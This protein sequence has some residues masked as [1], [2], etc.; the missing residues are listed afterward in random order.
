[1]QLN[2]DIIKALDG[3]FKT[4]QRPIQLKLFAG[5]HEKRQELIDFLSKVASISDKV[6]LIYSDTDFNVREGLTFEVLAE[7]ESTSIR[8]SGIPGGHEFN[9]F[10]LAILNSGGHPIKLD[11]G[12]QRQVKAI[13]AE[14][15]FEVI[16]SLDCHNCPDVVQTLNQFSLLNPK[17]S[18]EM[19]DGGTHKAF[20]DELNVQGVPTIFLNR[21]PFSSGKISVSEIIEKI[22]KNVEIAPTEAPVDNT[23]YDVAIIGGGPAAASAAIYTARK[24]L[25][26]LMLA[27][28]VGGQVA[29]TMA[30]EN[31]ISVTHTTGPELT[32]SLR[33][34]VESYDVSIRE[35]IRVNHIAK[36]VDSDNWALGLN[37]NET[38]QSKSVV[39][40]TGAKWREL[41]VPGEKENIGK[42]VAY[43]PHCDGPFFKGKDV[44]VVGGGNSG[45]EAA[46]D[47]AGIVKS[48]TVV[49]FMDTLKAD[50]VLID[51]LQDT[52]NAKIIT[53]VATE[54]ILA[55]S[56]SVT[57]IS[58]KNRSDGTISELP[59]DGVFIQIGLAPNSG[60]VKELVDVNKF[61]EIEVNPRCETDKPGIFAC[62]DVTTVPYK[63]IVVSIGEGAKAGLSAFEYILKAPKV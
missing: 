27:E 26:V 39:I 13:D 52:Q 61:G 5:N 24:G 14:L 53:G 35:E 29:E 11:E 19:I 21:K 3:Y 6:E 15:S 63:Q 57:G 41:G 45:V 49:E 55:N 58:L 30:I 60:F 42:G 47:L 25:K 7:N 50:Q 8:F 31:L 16:I 48:V 32:R 2:S 34:H 43:C 12:I 37:T 36:Q 44:V 46:L 38:I 54:K 62:G 56:K 33:A 22:G 40:A 1:M 10:V 23:L 9:S 4:L 20:A 28:K 59:T 17:I 51:R 18:S